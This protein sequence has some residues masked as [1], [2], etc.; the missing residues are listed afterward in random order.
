MFLFLFYLFLAYLNIIKWLNSIG[1]V[2]DTKC[3]NFRV[4]H[5]H[6]STGF[7][8]ST[9]TGSKKHSHVQSVHSELFQSVQNSRGQVGALTRARSSLQQKPGPVRH[10]LAECTS[11]KG[12]IKKTEVFKLKVP[13]QNKNWICVWQLFTQQNE[14]TTC[15]G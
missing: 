4:T 14:L 15:R 8:R 11:T 5:I 1:I 12:G 6:L 7:F 9:C 2:P 13:D 10:R 3:L